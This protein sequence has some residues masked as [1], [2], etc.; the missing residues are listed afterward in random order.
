MITIDFKRLD[1]ALVKVSE[2]NS[3]SVNPSHFLFVSETFRTNLKNF[4]N[5]VQWKSTGNHLYSIR[6]FI[7][8]EFKPKFCN[9]N[10][11][12]LIKNLRF[13]RNEL[14][15]M[16]MIF[17]RFASNKIEKRFSEWYG[18]RFGMVRNSSDSFRLHL[19]LKLSTEIITYR[20]FGI[21]FLE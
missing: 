1:L 3:I 7:P 8:N 6:D 4:L 11:Y 10:Q 21:R 13:R 9:Q 2:R 17:S 5:L 20:F 19:N 18:N 14:K 15:W 12:K 16:R